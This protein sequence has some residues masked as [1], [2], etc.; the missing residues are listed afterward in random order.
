MKW[1]LKR[2]ISIDADSGPPRYVLWCCG[3]ICNQLLNFFNI[4]CGHTVCEPFWSI[5]LN[6]TA[7]GCRLFI[8]CENHWDTFARIFGTWYF[9]YRQGCLRAGCREILTLKGV[10]WGSNSPLYLVIAGPVAV[11]SGKQPGIKLSG[12]CSKLSSDSI[13]DSFQVSVILREA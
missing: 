12:A 2:G 11:E 8:L 6:S 13:T 5:Q 9:S 1:G 3:G 4:G 7:N 10:F